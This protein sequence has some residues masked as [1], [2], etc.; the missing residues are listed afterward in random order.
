MGQRW[1]LRLSIVF[2]RA[3]RSIAYP[4]YITN[5]I[6]KWEFNM[7][8]SIKESN[9]ELSLLEKQYPL[10]ISRLRCL[11]F[12]KGHPISDLSRLSSLYGVD[13][14]EIERMIMLYR[15]GGMKLLLNS[16]AMNFISSGRGFSYNDLQEF[17]ISA[18]SAVSGSAAIMELLTYS[19]AS[20]TPDGLKVDV[21]S[22][23]SLRG[24]RLK[25]P[26]GKE[27]EDIYYGFG[28][29]VNYIILNRNKAAIKNQRFRLSE[30]VILESYTP[31]EAKVLAESLKQEKA[32]MLPDENGIFY[33]DIGPLFK[34]NREIVKFSGFPVF[35][36]T[37]RQ[38]I[39]VTDSTGKNHEGIGENKITMTKY[40]VEVI[41]QARRRG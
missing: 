1:T 30:K 19:Q 6:R 40:K 5:L 34:T 26:N 38:I 17:L 27:S 32:S 15:I 2:T 16:R 7:F 13:I 4:G 3:G 11:Q 8:L 9:Y 29:G 21:S 24:D 14:N 10:M 39:S 23:Q 41:P 28:R 37:Y 25:Y 31:E 12:L 36:A 33:D 20:M 35:E 18:E 22:Q